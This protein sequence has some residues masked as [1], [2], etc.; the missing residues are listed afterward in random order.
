[1]SIVGCM[2]RVREMMKK[3]FRPAIGHKDVSF[4][5]CC[6]LCRSSWSLGEIH[7]VHGHCYVMV[8]GTLCTNDHVCDASPIFRTRRVS[9]QQ[10]CTGPSAGPTLQ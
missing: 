10:R 4:P 6:W 1:M 5:Q 9:R 2:Q 8:I 7:F 3:V